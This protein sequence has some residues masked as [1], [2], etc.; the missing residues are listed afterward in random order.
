MDLSITRQKIGVK[1]LLQQAG[2]F[3]SHRRIRESGLAES[4]HRK[5]A[6][7]DGEP[8]VQPLKNGITVFQTC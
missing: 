2:D 3:Y 6:L 7:R 4:L 8:K 5:R 1:Y